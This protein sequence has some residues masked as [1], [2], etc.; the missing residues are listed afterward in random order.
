MITKEFIEKQKLVIEKRIRN[1][2]KDISENKKFVDLGSTDEDK[3]KEFEEFEEKIALMKSAK[4][5]INNLRKALK[6]IDEGS[7]GKCK[8]DGGPIEIGRLKAYPEAELC[9]EH[10]QK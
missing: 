7:Y 5:E 10:A 9:A 2:Q 8:V 4:R 3:T 6:R 1:L